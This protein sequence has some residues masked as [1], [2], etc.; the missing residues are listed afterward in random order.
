MDHLS[1]QGFIFAI[2]VTFNHSTNNGVIVVAL[3][4]TVTKTQ[5]LSQL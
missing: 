4:F 5:P 1:I 2:A 3:Q